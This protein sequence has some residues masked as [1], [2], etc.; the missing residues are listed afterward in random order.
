MGGERHL[1]WEGCWGSAT[2]TSPPFA[3]GLPRLVWGAH[4][5]LLGRTGMDD[6]R[7]ERSLRELVRAAD[8]L[9][10]LAEMAELM[11]DDEGAARFRAEASRQRLR[12]MALLDR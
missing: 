1:E 11:G 6:Q 12:A 2:T 10:A 8:R 7:Q 4:Q 3:P 9:A 5:T